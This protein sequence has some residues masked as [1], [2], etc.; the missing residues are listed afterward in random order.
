MQTVKPSRV[1]VIQFKRIGDVLLST[2]VIGAIKD[3]LPEI[4]LGFLTESESRPILENNPGLD[5][6]IVWDGK[7]RNNPVYYAKRMLELRRNGFDMVIDLQGS[8]RSSLL[9]LLIGAKSRI[10]FDYRFRK[11]FYNQVVK[12]DHRP[13][14]GPAFKLDILSPLG[15]SSQEIRPELVLTRESSSWAERFLHNRHFNRQ[16]FKVALSPVSRRPYKRW[17]LEYFSEL[18]RH[19][20]TQ[21]Q[22]KVILFWGPGEKSVV[23]ELAHS[24]DSGAIVSE[25][26]NS[27]LEAAALLEQCDVLIGNDNAHQ[28]LATAVGIPTFTIYGPSDSVSWTYPDNKNHRF[29]KG[30]C[31]CDKK[32]KFNCPGPA[33]LA[34]ITVQ[35]AREV[36]K[37]FLEEIISRKSPKKIAQA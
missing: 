1:L 20:T 2:P 27:L 25:P 3:A 19:L 34:G 8:F 7:K 36:L 31:T 30:N 13:K 23:E 37:P 24:A 22:A 17:P 28:H 32:E 6:L 12:R 29:I 16:H 26:T 11:T 35:Q 5:D 21:Y 18:C 33:C 14:Y 10:G 15:I 9:S 4:H